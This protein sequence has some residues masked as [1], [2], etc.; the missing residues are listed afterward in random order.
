[1]A[2][3]GPRLWSGGR[4]RRTGRRCLACRRLA[5][6]ALRA[7]ATPPV[8]WPQSGGGGGAHGGRVNPV[9][10]VWVGG[11]EVKERVKE[12]EGGRVRE[13]ERREGGRGRGSEREGSACEPA[14]PPLES[15][16]PPALTPFLD[17]TLPASASTKVGWKDLDRYPSVVFAFGARADAKVHRSCHLPPTLQVIRA[18]SCPAQPI[19][20]I[21]FIT[22][23]QTGCSAT[24]ATPQFPNPG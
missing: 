12:C 23:Q 8:G 13:E 11:G 14:G 16:T 1:M 2:G 20:S 10:G 22:Q 24:L 17:P 21:L 6:P 3:P 4:R 18:R 19:M 5:A 7:A 15:R 9:Q